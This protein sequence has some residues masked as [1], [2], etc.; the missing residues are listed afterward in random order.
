MEQQITV[1]NEHLAAVGMTFSRR[2][3]QL[4]NKQRAVW[5]DET[6][7]AIRLLPEI[8][9]EPIMTNTNEPSEG[10]EY[11]DD[12]ID[13]CLLCIAKKRVKEKRQLLKSIGVYIIGCILIFMYMTANN[14]FGDDN[15]WS[16]YVRGNSMGLAQGALLTWSALLGWRICT[17]VYARVKGTNLLKNF[18]RD[19]VKAEYE[20]LKV[21]RASKIEAEMERL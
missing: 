16:G 18:S 6:R 10:S 5:T 15:Y 19:P 12:S 9:E 17:Y 21:M 14:Y 11:K 4:V 7:G 1:Y 13:N 3:K 20:K 2:A 8:K